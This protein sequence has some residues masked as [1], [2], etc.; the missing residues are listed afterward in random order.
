VT[1]RVLIIEDNPINRELID[2]LLRA[3]GFETLK[4]LDGAV[5]LDMA[6]RERPDL[7]V[8]DIQMPVMDGIEFAHHVKSDPLLRTT[9]LVA[10]T[11]L[12]MVG[13]RDRILVE[14]FDGYITKPI[15]PSTFVA[16]INQYLQEPLRA[17]VPR[18]A[19][20]TPA[21]RVDGGKARVLV[22]DDTPYNLELERD[23]LAPHGYDVVAVAT[24]DEAWAAMEQ[25]L[26]DLILSDIGMR[27][28]SG[29]DFIR[30]VKADERL[31]HIPFVFLSSTH[32][33]SAS[34]ETGMRLGA[35][36][37]LLRPLDPERLLDEVADCLG[38]RR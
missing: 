17:P 30:R 21:R 31:R 16:S 8:C 27:V 35:A 11:A 9:P 18:P 5:G 29:F 2:Y 22:L 7:I 24:I 3:H 6:R 32:W 13:D 23:L 26:P 10:L 14:G 34:I 4:A 33:D 38:H 20:A 15:E 36:R 25:Q 1:T 12:A 19:T 37:Y 28:G